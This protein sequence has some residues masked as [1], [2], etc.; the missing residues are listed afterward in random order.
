M[1]KQIDITGMNKGEAMEALIIGGYSYKDAEKKWKD[2]GARSNA[3]GFRAV[4][5]AAL[6][7]GFAGTDKVDLIQFMEQNGASAND[8]KQY[9]HFLA[10]AKLIADVRG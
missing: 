2:E 10:I 5:Y 1:T 3:T 6:K 9:S 7:D 8:I 4:F